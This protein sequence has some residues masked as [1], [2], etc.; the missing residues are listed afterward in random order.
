M[1][2]RVTLVIEVSV[3]KSCRRIPARNTH[4]DRIGHTA[5]VHFRRVIAIA[6][7]VKV[8]TK[9]D[10]NV[11]VPGTKIGGVIEVPGHDQGI[12]AAAR[13]QVLE[14][15]HRC[16]FQPDQRAGCNLR[17]GAVA[18]V[19][20][21]RQAGV[22]AINHRVVSCTAVNDVRTRDGPDFVVTTHPV[23]YVAAAKPAQIVCRWSPRHLYMLD[24]RHVS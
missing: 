2:I 22:I 11:V 1:N 10:E 8:V 7:F 3:E 21:R 4:P 9:P 16:H 20:I 14:P 13:A 15:L 18:K 6:S 23:E 19:E 17:K 12:I 5:P 24:I